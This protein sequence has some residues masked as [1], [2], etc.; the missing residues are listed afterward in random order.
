MSEEHYDPVPDY[1]RGRDAGGGGGMGKAME[2][3]QGYWWCDYHD[4]IHV[5]ELDSWTMEHRKDLHPLW[6]GR[7]TRR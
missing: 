6:V 7:R 3:L 4:E 5:G 1:P 2:R